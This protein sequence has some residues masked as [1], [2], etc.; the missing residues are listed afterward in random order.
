MGV[1]AF[2]RRARDE[3]E[4]YGGDRWVFVRELVQNARDAGATRV[5]FD[6]GRTPD[7]GERI[8]VADDGDGMSLEHARRFLFTLYASSKRDR[9]DAAGRFGVGFWSVLRYEPDAVTVRSRSAGGDGWQVRLSGA[10]EEAEIGSAPIGSGTEIVLERRPAG[11]DTADRI[12]AA[13]HAESRLVRQ[14]DRPDRPLEIVVD[15]RPAAA[16]TELAPPL[17]RF[18]RRG[19]RGAVAFGDRPLV[20]LSVRGFRVRTVAAL[21]DL[22]PQDSG[23]RRRRAAGLADGL[24]P[25]VVLDSDRLEVLMSRGEARDGREL[26]RIVRTAE[27]ELGRLV[28]RELDRL[29]PTPAHRRAVESVRAAF[30]AVGSRALAVAAVAAVALALIAAFLVVLPT[31]DRGER[32]AVERVPAPAGGSASATALYRPLDGR[33]RGLSVGGVG[34][35]PADAA[36]RYRPGDRAL[37]IGG[38]RVRGVEPSGRVTIAPVRASEGPGI[39]CGGGCVELTV[40]YDAPAGPLRLPFPAGTVVDPETVRLDGRPVAVAW[41]AAGEPT[42]ELAR[43]GTGELRYGA[44]PGP[45]P[46]PSGTGGWPPLPTELRRQAALWSSRPPAEAADTAVELVRRRVAY[47][48]GPALAVRYG[49]ALRTGRSVV[50]AALELGAGDC[51]VQNMLVASLLE[52]AG[53]PARLAIGWIGVGGTAVGG[54]HAWAEYRDADGVWRAAD[55]SVTAGTIPAAATVTEDGG[56]ADAWPPS[57][58]LPAGGRRG[59]WAWM[60]ALA[61]AGAAG[62]WTVFAWRR[63]RLLREHEDGDGVTLSQLVDGAVRRPEAWRG[64]AALAERPLLATWGTAAVSLRRARRE[65]ARGRLYAA[66]DPVAAALASAATVLDQRRPECRAAADGLG[67]PDLDRWRR[68]LEGV[69]AHPLLR[70]AQDRLATFGVSARL[71]LAEDG[72]DGLEVLAPPGE[73]PSVVVAAGGEPWRRVGV[74][75][76]DGAAVHAVLEE[77]V[78]ALLPPAAARRVLEASARR[79][80]LAGEVDP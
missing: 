45:E 52:T 56:T 10:L 60:G 73:T 19:L 24:A 23:R 37:L 28:R 30:G 32:R 75:G 29:A 46:P 9:R 64:A 72:V 16:G 67:A 27:R 69:E 76:C 2:R 33:Y 51:D 38:L 6:V 57:P 48:R 1:G 41:T 11:D 50:E 31:S 70:R 40:V 4:R 42:V 74:S 44:A 8:T 3:A 20:E 13:V 65:A 14:R 5:L 55:A 34:E 35:I 47:D 58:P 18:R 80:V 22:R 26:E 53:I 21:A 12:R 79:T 15:G 78:P 43:A 71:A 59:T 36:I 77:V 25:R 68:M 7:G 39:P 62:A 63:R 66:S 17:I 61:G 54:L 49:L